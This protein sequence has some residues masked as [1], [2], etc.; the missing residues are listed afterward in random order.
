MV[1]DAPPEFE[2]NKNLEKLNRIS[3]TKQDEEIERQ[4][5]LGLEAAGSVN[6]RTISLF[7]RG[8]QPAF[9]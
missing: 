4:L 5:A 7:A 2:G 9:A 8:S 3:Q 6:N 1:D